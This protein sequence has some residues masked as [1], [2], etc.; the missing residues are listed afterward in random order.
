MASIKFAT[1]AMAY[2]ALERIFDRIQWGKYQNKATE[3]A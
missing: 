2:F 3:L 1:N